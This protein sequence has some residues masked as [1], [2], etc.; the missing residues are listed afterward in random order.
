MRSV[1]YK[2]NG[3][4]Y[5]SSIV[6]SRAVTY[7]FDALRS[8]AGACE[9]RTCKPP[10]S[11]NRTT[12]ISR[13]IDALR[14]NRANADRPGRPTGRVDLVSHPGGHGFGR[15][16]PCDGSRLPSRFRTI[17]TFS[18]NFLE[19][20]TFGSTFK[21]ASGL[22]PCPCH[23]RSFGAA[24]R[25]RACTKRRASRDSKVHIEMP[26][27]EVLLI[28]VPGRGPMHSI[29]RRGGPRSVR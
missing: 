29:R 22:Q 27:K 6:R 7:N 15:G 1:H 20:K 23:R 10:L 5:A 14:C 28:W 19:S 4:A 3:L 18:C 13:E 25:P 24:E 2:Q 16:L 26:P 12:P 9:R 21:L 11:Q 8:L 17:N